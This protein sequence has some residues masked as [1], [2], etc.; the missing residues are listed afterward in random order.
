MNAISSA[1]V[2]ELQSQAA[3]GHKSY[4]DAH[5]HYEAVGKALEQ[6]GAKRSSLVK[7]L[8]ASRQALS[9]AKQ[10][11]IEAAISGDGFSE[12]AARVAGLENEAKLLDATLTSYHSGKYADLK[13]AV[14]VA[15]VR[16]LD[17]QVL[18]EKARREVWTAE[19]QLN[20][21]PL[22]Q[23]NGSLELKWTGV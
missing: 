4:S 1:S 15:Q 20:L 21:A 22:A 19:L 5:A 18:S 14:L 23:A 12:A 13:R 7:R 11:A 17:L 8:D 2:A 16:M 3:A 10:T 9:A 6:A